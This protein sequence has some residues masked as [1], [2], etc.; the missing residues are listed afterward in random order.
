VNYF[1][2]A[3]KASTR[4]EVVTTIL[5]L[6][7]NRL[8]EVM[9]TGNQ[10]SLSFGNVGKLASDR[11]IVEYTFCPKFGEATELR[12]YETGETGPRK[13]STKDKISLSGEYIEEVGGHRAIS[14]DD[15]SSLE[16]LSNSTVNV[17]KLLD[18][19]ARLKRKRERRARRKERKS[20]K[21]LAPATPPKPTISVEKFNELTESLGV[22]ELT[23]KLLSPKLFYS[24]SSTTQAVEASPTLA[25][26]VC[27]TVP[28]S[29]SPNQANLN[30]VMEDAYARH[31]AKVLREL[32]QDE[33]DNRR[34]QESLLFHS[35]AEK[36]K[37]QEK[38]ERDRLYKESLLAQIEQKKLQIE[39]D[40]HNNVDR[41]SMFQ[42]IY[43]DPKLSGA[44]TPT[45]FSK[46]PR[47]SVLVN[48]GTATPEKFPP[49]IDNNK[50]RILEERRKKQEL[51]SQLDQQVME[52]NKE[53]QI[54][55]QLQLDQD[56]KMIEKTKE[57]LD[58]E[59]SY[60]QQKKREMG[61]EMRSAWLNQLYLKKD[62]MKTSP[63]NSLGGSV[64]LTP[65][66]SAE[67]RLDKTAFF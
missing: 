31:E 29:R 59:K 42:T 4:K 16:T 33:E 41:T 49:I 40:Q 57:D 65:I 28:L 8:G 35:E 44:S 18:D 3:Q 54:A 45:Q 15:F 37:K 20:N 26:K 67:K 24:P 66:R 13:H 50:E 27:T 23:E 11:K 6:L 1:L 63:R 34:H 56:W 12:Y 21:Y 47:A 9:S 48:S 38:I 46:S 36:K 25:A 60:V 39:L 51:C 7:Y 30:A 17:S 55:K 52:K 64:Q 10:V 5:K 19:E 53:V 61:E 62:V 2:I 43:Y 58:I 32:Q 14:V 22:K